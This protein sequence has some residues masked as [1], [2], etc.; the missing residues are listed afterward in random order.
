MEDR[1][2]PTQGSVCFPAEQETE[3][4]EAVFKIPWMCKPS[5]GPWDLLRSPLISLFLALKWMIGKIV[6]VCFGPE[7]LRLILRNF[8]SGLNNFK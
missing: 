8:N 3:A 2:D 1:G 4:G 6:L 7:V 5:L